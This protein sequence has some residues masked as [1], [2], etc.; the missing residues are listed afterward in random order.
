MYWWN[1]PA[2]CCQPQIH[3]SIKMWESRHGQCD[4]P[5]LGLGRPLQDAEISTSPRPVL[6]E[7]ST[8]SSSRCFSSPALIHIVWSFTH[9]RYS[10][11]SSFPD[12]TDLRVTAQSVE[13]CK[14]HAGHVAFPL[15]VYA[16][17]LLLFH[18]VCLCQPQKCNHCS[19][20]TVYFWPL[21]LHLHSY[22]NMYIF[23]YF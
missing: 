17:L 10:P 19:S 6:P 15:C 1:D 18:I 9:V 3:I 12:L 22:I 7:W 5:L 16:K 4:D 20:S 13:P 21:L 2:I 11:L 8:A 23:I 14:R